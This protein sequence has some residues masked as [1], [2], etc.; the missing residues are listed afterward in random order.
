MNMAKCK[1]C[2]KRIDFDERDGST[3]IGKVL[4]TVAGKLIKVPEYGKFAY[5]RRGRWYWHPECYPDKLNIK[6]LV[7][8]EKINAMAEEL[9][10][11]LE[12]NSKLIESRDHWEKMTVSANEDASKQSAR[13][14][15]LLKL[16]NEAVEHNNQL[17]AEVADYHKLQADIKEQLENGKD[18]T[19][20]SG[21]S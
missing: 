4:K 7:D 11:T 2:N 12:E 16:L 18:D 9:Q 5:I 8:D 14:D 6:T 15:D 20:E 10:K 1:I 17:T 3:V 21:P 19:K 13:G